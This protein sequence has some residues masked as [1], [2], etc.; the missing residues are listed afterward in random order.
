MFVRNG[1]AKRLGWVVVV[2]AF[3]VFGSGLL[4][5]PGVLSAAEGDE[6]DV[7][8]KWAL[9]AL[10]AATGTERKLE[11][12]T[13]DMNLKAGDQ[14]KMM[15]EPQKKC[16]VYVILHTEQEGAKLLFPYTLDQFN[17]DYETSKKY[18]IPK[19]DDWLEL[20]EH[21]GKDTVYLLA[22]N[23]RLSSIEDLFSHREA[24]EPEKKSEISQQIL[25]EIRKLKKQHREFAAPAERP[26]IIG[27]AIRGF[28]KPQPAGRPDVATIAT[29]ISSNDFYART[30]TLE[31]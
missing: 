28:P 16:F 23:Q 4:P 15:V 9:G 1:K 26:V 24:A 29:E 20:G 6:N 21:A 17:A 18:Y 31:H 7:S 8:F 19:G 13:R 3:L 5:G 11:P 2:F 22:S 14:F 25:V 27:G 12:I 10:V 30:F